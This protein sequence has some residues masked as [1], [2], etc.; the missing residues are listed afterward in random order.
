MA[1]N[2]NLDDLPDVPDTAVDDDDR[3]APA[4]SDDEA[5]K[6]IN[7][8]ISPIGWLLLVSALGGGGATGYYM[9]Q[10]AK[11][12]S[13]EDSERDRG[14]AEIAQVLQRDLGPTETAR[15]IRALYG[16]YRSDGVRQAA[17]RI[18]AGLKDA[19]SVPLLIEGLDRPGAPRAQ[20]ALGLAEIGSPA[21]DAAKSALM[22]V[23]PLTDPQT[24]RIEVA[25]AL[26]VL[27][28]PAAWTTVRELLETNRLQMVTSLDG[29][30][31]FDP[32]LVARMAGR[33]RLR[34]LVTSRNLASRQLAAISL[35][36]IA[37]PE[38]LDDLGV[39]S[40]DSEES[41]A[42][43]AAIG[44]G[45]TGDR[46]AV[47]GIM[48]FLGR[49]PNARDGVL[50]ALA[51]SSGAQGLGVV[52]QGSRD[53][54]TRARATQLLR[55]Q[56][57][58]GAGDALFA[59]LEAATASTE[60]P[61]RD[62]KKNAI[63]GL[64][65]IGDARAVEG[66]VA[67]VQ[68]GIEHPADI[69]GTQ[70]AK[71]ALEQ[72]RRIPG[73]S[74]RAKDR[75]LAFLRMPTSDFVR[76]PLILALA[77]SGDPALGAVVQPF[78]AQADAQEGAA[79]ALCALRAPQCFS[80]V[81]SQARQPPNLRMVEETVRDE[82]I[83]IRRR[84]ALRGMAWAAYEPVPGSGVTLPAMTAA[85]R[86]MLVRELR[87]IIEDPTDRPSLREEAGYAL[88]AIADGP[89]LT[90]IA[91]QATNASA[92]EERRIYYIFALRARCTPTIATQ[93]VQTYLRRGVNL[94]VMRGAAVAAGFGA[95]DSTVDA[96]LPL[97]QGNDAQDANV[98]FAAAVALVLGGNA[99]AATALV[100]VL[101]TN[102]ELTGIL[103]N[104]FSPR[105]SGNAGN[106][107]VLIERSEILP[108]TRAMFEDGRVF[109]RM[110]VAQILERGRNSK[111][112]VFGLTALV[113]RLRAGWDSPIGAGMLEVR[114]L[115][116]QAALGTD[117][118][119]REVAFSALRA[120]ADRGSLHALQRQTENPASAELARR[121][122]LG[123]SASGG[124]AR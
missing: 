9:F 21:A 23:L 63:F 120:L 111:Q 72:I 54:A 95:D 28:E 13:L 48:A 52:I 12:E 86:Q 46:R 22:R 39:L 119:R 108:L 94:E 107:S 79:Q 33:D 110:E 83:L 116:R 27:N 74:A 61:A 124:P 117:A 58:P 81:A 26:T 45:R 41:V 77:M 73:A 93:L 49:F 123:M 85:Q 53:L 29:R 47:D 87:R 55:D 121:E 50:A 30:R 16:R 14:R 2:D 100:E 84:S 112:F 115:I 97:L 67:Y 89:T 76:S 70:D 15:E 122:L 62:M 43:E 17:R 75:L 36:E 69:N 56:R 38:V 105:A 101:S 80:T 35:A 114:Q 1:R 60:E 113:A 65:E 44:L 34:E 10:S 40:R 20:A 42:R 109:R 90:E 8:R 5:A 32:A 37:S 104:F 71:L 51:T 91:A 82:E 96:L 118:H 25:W 7:R 66:L 31:S 6:Q 99:R 18:L 92:P 57:D 4:Q 103:Q 59:A 98:R 24:D 88:A 3:P 11:Q 68:F 106:N 102:D 64:A 19:E 78:L